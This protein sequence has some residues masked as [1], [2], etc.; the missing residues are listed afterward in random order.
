MKREEIEVGEEEAVLIELE[1]EGEGLE[2]EGTKLYEYIIDHE[3]RAFSVSAYAPPDRLERY[4]E[5][6]SV[7]DR[8]VRTL[9]F[10]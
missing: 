8:A 7:I 5:F 6:Q 4:A 3:G 9:F 1:S 2:E 10:F